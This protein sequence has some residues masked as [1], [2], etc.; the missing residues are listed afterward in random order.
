MALYKEYNSAVKKSRRR[1]TIKKLL[2]ASAVLAVGFLATAVFAITLNGHKPVDQ[3]AVAASSDIT[4]QTVPAAAIRVE[5]DSSMETEDAGIDALNNQYPGWK[6]NTQGDIKSTVVVATEYQ[7]SANRL[8]LPKIQLTCER[9]SYGVSFVVDE[10]LGTEVASIKY[11]SD[12]VAETTQQWELSETYSSAYP[13]NPDMFINL[14]SA[15]NTLTVTY[16][17]FGYDQDK[18]TEFD[19]S[20]SSKAIGEFRSQ[21]AMGASPNL[22]RS[23][24]E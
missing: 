18:T 4:M 15:A 12:L 16:Q 22:A 11:S 24:A 5:A 20:F 19:L 21:C 17:T 7:T 10:I 8:Y 6:Y 23:S 3:L 1:K 14:L 9:L 13:P 2:V